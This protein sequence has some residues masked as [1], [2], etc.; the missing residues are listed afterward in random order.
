MD[1]EVCRDDGNSD[2]PSS[3]LTVPYVWLLALA[4]RDIPSLKTAAI[5]ITLGAIHHGAYMA[6]STKAICLKTNPVQNE[7]LQ[8]KNTR[9]LSDFYQK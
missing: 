1:Y 2:N 3:Y 7:C 5:V 4:A 8:F 9:R 6:N